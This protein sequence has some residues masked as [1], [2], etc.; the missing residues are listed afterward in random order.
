MATSTGQ[1]KGEELGWGLQI[2]SDLM[3]NR[4]FPQGLLFVYHQAS[5][6]QCEEA[7]SLTNVASK[8]VSVRALAPPPGSGSDQQVGCVQ[9]GG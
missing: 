6:N 1:L 3:H 5:V 8:P 7:T 4:G 2:I 9:L